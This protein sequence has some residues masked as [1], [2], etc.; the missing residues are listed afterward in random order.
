MADPKVS[1]I[2]RF[3]CSGTKPTTGLRDGDQKHEHEL[4]S[5]E[6]HGLEIK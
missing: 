3:H 6:I 5:K 1:F 4:Y 2:Q